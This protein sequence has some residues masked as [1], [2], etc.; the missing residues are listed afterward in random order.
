MG[1]TKTQ[2]IA[3]F[4]KSVMVEKYGIYEIKEYF[5]DTRD[6]LCYA[7]NDNQNATIGLMEK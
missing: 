1:M 5:A 6:T 2:G 7:T 4:F 3:D